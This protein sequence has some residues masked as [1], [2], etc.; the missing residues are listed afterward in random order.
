MYYKCFTL[1][2]FVIQNRENYIKIFGFILQMFRVIFICNTIPRKNPA[3]H[4]EVSVLY[5]KLCAH[6]FGLV[7][8]IRHG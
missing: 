5:Y 8:Q 7:L 4:D 6:F 2:L 1:I 3:L